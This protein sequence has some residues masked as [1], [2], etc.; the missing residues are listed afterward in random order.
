[1]LKRSFILLMLII[2]LLSISSCNTLCNVKL[3]LIQ[4]EEYF[5]EPISYIDI[6]KQKGSNIELTDLEMLVQMINPDFDLDNKTLNYSLYQDKKLKEKLDYDFKVNKDLIVYV[7]INYLDY[8]DVKL[9]GRVPSCG[10]YYVGDDI[11][12]YIDLTS[13]NENVLVFPKGALSVGTFYK[14]LNNKTVSFDDLYDFYYNY[15]KYFPI[16]YQEKKINFD[17]NNKDK[18]NFKIN[19]VESDFVTFP[20]TFDDNTALIYVYYNG[21][22]LPLM[23]WD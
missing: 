4:D 8:F 15:R 23:L 5:T 19:D 2:I 16:T 6:Q 14:T 13:F 10:F 1:M 20:Y 17:I 7:Y 9:G 21:E 18:I 11:N 3:Y 12:N 22:L